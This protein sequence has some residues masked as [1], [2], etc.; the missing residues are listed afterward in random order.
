MILKK[1]EIRHWKVIQGFFGF[2][3]DTYFYL[4]NDTAKIIVWVSKIKFKPKMDSSQSITYI[5]QM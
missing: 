1:C 2:C 5:L 3:H 4:Q